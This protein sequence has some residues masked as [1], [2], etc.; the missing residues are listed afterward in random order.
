[1]SLI[2]L[3]DLSKYLLIFQPGRFP[4][5]KLETVWC[6]TSILLFLRPLLN[7]NFYQLSPFKIN[8]KI[9]VM[10]LK[11]NT[12]KAQTDFCGKFASFFTYIVNHGNI[13]QI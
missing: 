10:L 7:L 1:M 9:S 8:A 3:K 2:F 4:S 5:D 13:G 12:L 6:F 11:G